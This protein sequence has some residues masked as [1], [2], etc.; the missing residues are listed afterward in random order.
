M[1]LWQVLA[2][3]QSSEAPVAPV[4]PV[5]VTELGRARIVATGDVLM[6]GMVKTAAREVD[7]QLD[8]QSLNHGGYDEL[9]REVAPLL[10]E[11]DLAFTNMEFPIAPRTGKG[12]R[13][14]VFNAPPVVL[15]A[16]VGSGIDV[17]SFANNHVYDQGRKGFVETLEHLDAAPLRYIGAGRTC[18]EAIEPRMLVAGG[19]WI[20]W[21]GVTQLQNDWLNEGPDQPCVAELDVER[22]IEAAAHAR[23]EG[24]DLVVLSVHW[25]VEYEVQPRRFQHKL[26]HELVEGGVDILLGHHPHVLQPI[27]KIWTSDGRLALVAYSLGN[28]VSNQS[29]YY[30]SDRHDPHEGNPRDGVLLGLD[31]VR[32]R[33][34][35]GER[36]IVRT[37]LAG[38][39]LTPTWTR[40]DREASPRIAVELGTAREAHALSILQAPLPYPEPATVQRVSGLGL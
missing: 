18:A 33:Y 26:A 20:A 2:C 27:E 5:A 14:M 28:F 38:L 37:E 34:G 11:A 9:F 1:W 7:Q 40:N 39:D 16:L 3:V 25:G 21:I 8:G 23:R 31:L 10:S 24:A 17:V 13:S 19:L 32:R 35:T 12:T 15:D 4:V 29:A 30:R 22:V 6:H 36:A